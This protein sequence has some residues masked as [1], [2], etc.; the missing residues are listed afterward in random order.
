MTVERGLI[1][2]EHYK[3][4]LRLYNCVKKTNLR[5]CMESLHTV[6]TKQNLKK[7]SSVHMS[8]LLEDP[9]GFF[10]GY[11]ILRLKTIKGIQSIWGKFK[12]KM[13]SRVGKLL[14]FALELTK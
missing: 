1:S 2:H 9:L 3:Y 6:V 13:R 12:D 7:K 4:I 11:G 5:A 14:T 8:S 10:S